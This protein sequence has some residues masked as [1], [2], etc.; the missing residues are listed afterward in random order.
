MDT[1]HFGPNR[2]CGDTSK[3]SHLLVIPATEQE[4]TQGAQPWGTERDAEPTNKW[5]RVPRICF[6]LFSLKYLAY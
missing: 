1:A 3:T 4:G 2:K 6:W 5:N